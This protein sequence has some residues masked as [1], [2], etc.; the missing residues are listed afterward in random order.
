MG[1]LHYYN[2]FAI[3]QSQLI[4]T[5]RVIQ[6]LSVSLF[7]YYCNSTNNCYSNEQHQTV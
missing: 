1:P 3:K 2:F 7:H 5:S 6:F 4:V